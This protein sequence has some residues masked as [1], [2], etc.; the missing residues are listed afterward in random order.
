MIGTMRLDWFTPD[1]LPDWGDG[2]LFLVGTEGTLELRKNLD[3]E[4]RPGGD[5]MFV[6]NRQR[7]AT[8]TAPPSRSPITAISCEEVRDRAG[9]ML[10][11]SPMFSASRLA[12][13]CQAE[14]RFFTPNWVTPNGSR[15]NQD[16]G[17][18]ACQ[19]NSQIVQRQRDAAVG[20]REIRPSQ[21][22]ED[23]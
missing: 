23:R 3:I 16:F 21:M 7:P 8:R 6:A 12:L 5:H 20:R 19:D 22:Q 17:Q 10:D 13:R 1:G 9:P 2:R 18:S 11:N 14:A 15:H 4:G